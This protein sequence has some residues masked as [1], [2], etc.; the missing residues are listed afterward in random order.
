MATFR[1]RAR[2]DT[3][4]EPGRELSMPGLD[5][6]ALSRGWRLVRALSGTDL[7]RVANAAADAWAGHPGGGDVI[8]VGLA[9]LRNAYV[10]AIAG[11]YEAPTAPHGFR[12]ANAWTGFPSARM[13][14]MSVCALQLAIILPMMWIDLRPHT[15]L[16]HVPKVRTDDAAFDARFSVRST[17]PERASDLLCPAVRALSM[18]R[19]DWAFYL[20]GNHIYVICTA[21]FQSGEDISTRIAALQAFAAA[22]PTSALPSPATRL[23]TLPDGTVLDGSDP[24]RVEAAAAAMTRQQ[25]A[26][27]TADFERRRSE[28]RRHQE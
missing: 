13:H 4:G 21:T 17:E 8:G 11:P 28:R 22:I 20:G 3:V 23:P 27:L 18:N 6:Y 12:A 7:D 25:R 19:D 9:Q 24:E 14:G 1:R 2:G 16:T 26:D 15:T 10:G 5:E